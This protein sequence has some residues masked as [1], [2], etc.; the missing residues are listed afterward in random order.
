MKKKKGYSKDKHCQCGKLILNKSPQC[1]ECYLKTRPK[2]SGLFKKGFIP[3]N[4][5]KPHQKRI[6]EN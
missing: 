4:K 3:W 5:G 6:G 2:H 1:W